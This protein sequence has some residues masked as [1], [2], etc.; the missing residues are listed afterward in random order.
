MRLRVGEPER[1]SPRAAEYDPSSD[2]ELLAETLHVS[3]E[4][5]GRIVL[6]RGV[7][8]ALAR[9]TLVEEDDPVRGRIEEPALERF[10]PAARAAVDEQDGQP[11]RIP[12]LLVVDLVDRR[13]LEVPVLVRLDLRVELAHERASAR[14]VSDTGRRSRSRPDGSTLR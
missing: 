13:D 14:G 7:G 10:G 6:E 3:H 2:P 9:P 4:V 11:G 1:A 5:P 8:P 12:A